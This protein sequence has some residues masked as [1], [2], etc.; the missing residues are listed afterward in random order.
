MS[1]K[2]TNRACVWV[3]ANTLEIQELPTKPV[4]PDDVLVQVMATGICGSDAH[5][6]N[7]AHVSRQLVLGHES[8]GIIV[9]VGSNVDKSRVGQRVAMEPGF[10]CLKCESCLQGKQNIC[11]NLAYCGLDPTD[12]TLQQYFI[13]GA[14]MAIPIPDKISW[15]EAG[16]IQPLA[17]AVQLGRRAALTA[18]KTL[19]IF[20]C[21]PLGIL[22]IAVAKA[23]GVRKIIVFDVEQSRMD[24]AVQYG[25][26]VGII[27]PNNDG[28]DDALEFAQR[29]VAQT[30]KE[31]GLDHGVDVSVEASGVESCAQMA[32]A[33]LKP[34]GTC[35]QAGL[36]KPLTA[37]PLLML[38]AKELTIKGTVRFTPGCYGD[39]IDLVSRGKVDL[40]SLITS[41]YPLTRAS[42]AFVAQHARKD[43]K[44]VIMNQE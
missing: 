11:T 29:F 13:C 34:G 7:S 23:S 40:R 6:W 44:I 14:H 21:G 2:Y 26:D 9:E 43:I 12:G 31:Q 10:A 1:A 42:D 28:S 27:S 33:I 15:E 16:A 36:G 5:N 38:T 25:A 24:F 20:G 30:L 22:V 35:I 41:T 32:I 4:G 18:N 8:A 39:A 37:V 19:A 3:A 17:I